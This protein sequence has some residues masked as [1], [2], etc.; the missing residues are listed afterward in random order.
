MNLI[1]LTQAMRQAQSTIKFADLFV[2]DMLATCIGRLRSVD[3]DVLRDLKRE[4]CAF[5]SHTGE[6]KVP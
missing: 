5:N 3:A 1:E 6:W 4:L 2:Q